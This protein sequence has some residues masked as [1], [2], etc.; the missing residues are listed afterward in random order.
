MRLAA[1]LKQNIVATNVLFSDNFI[2][3]LFTLSCPVVGRELG[4]TFVR[5]DV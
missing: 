4:N 2:L 3:Y 5:V 1:I